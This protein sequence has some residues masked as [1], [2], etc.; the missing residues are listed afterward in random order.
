MNR[1]A[2]VFPRWANTVALASILGMAFCFPLL[3]GLLVAINRS[4]YVTRID[5][6]LD[7]PV[8][9]SHAHHV[10]GL[11]ID[12]RYCHV[13]VETSSYAGIPSTE[14]CMTC[15]SQVWKDAPVLQPV[16]DSFFTGSALQWNRVN[17]VPD[18]VFFDHSAHVNKGVAC[19]ECHGAVEQMP[20]VS[21]QKTLFMGWCLECHRHP[22]GAMG[23]PADVYRSRPASP[24]RMHVHS[25]LQAQNPRS[26]PPRAIP[27]PATR[28]VAIERLTDCTACHR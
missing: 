20:L 24:D 22:D 16:R 7:Q 5:V 23:N 14:T 15:H 17:N 3:A 18:F 26:E 12:C 27:E 19:R 2:Q 10:G 28:A 25:W 11:G 1:E 9:F 21:K 13:T 8:P 4:P 6:P